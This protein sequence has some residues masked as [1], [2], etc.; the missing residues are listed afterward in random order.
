MRQRDPSVL[1]AG[2]LLIS[3][4][5]IA[6]EPSCEGAGAV[7]GE[8]KITEGQAGFGVFLDNLDQFGTS[9]AMLGDVD[10]D[11]V[12]DLAVGVI[13]DDDGGSGRGAVW[14]LFLNAD[15][16]VRAQQKISDAEGGLVG[17]LDD[18]DAFGRAVAAIGDLDGDG[19]P[20]LAVGA[21]SDDDGGSGRGAVWILLL[22]ANGAVKAE[23]KISSAAGGL[24]GPLANFIAFGCGV[25]SLGDLDGD[26]VADLAVGARN[27]ASGG[28]ARGAVWVLFLN[29]NGTVKAEQKIS[30]VDG[31]FG[32][33]LLDEDNFGR[34]VSGLGDLDGDG[35]PDLAVGAPLDNDGGLDSGAVWIVFLNA[36][37]T[38]KGE[39][40]IAQ[41]A[42]GFT[43]AL[44]A[45]DYF[46]ESIAAIGD[47]DGDG[48]TDLAAGAS[49]DDDGGSN[50]GAAWLLLLNADGTVKAER[51]ISSTSGGFT[52]PIA[53]G[54]NFG[55]TLAALGDLNGDGVP[56]L[57]VGDPL[58]DEGGANSG[59]V[60]MLFLTG[61]AASCPGDTNGDLV[62][63][64]A[65]LNTVLGDYNEVGA[66]LPGDVD[67]DGDV[68]FADLNI[69]LGA[70]NT[71]CGA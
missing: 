54:N 10:G 51:K 7:A 28:L 11:G 53:D 27:S 19:V 71:A 3:G 62:V 57:A 29:A 36:D 45:G 52:G 1:V 31:G 5:A 6:G 38:V 35:A 70:Y 46:G 2:L 41:S 68:D 12:G 20:D 58:D 39:Q 16:T 4:S 23:Q 60:W 25:S 8:V 69:V 64:F 15:G 34:S 56:D 30:D 37:G 32:G 47:L 43:G 13:G 9:A 40:K 24:A 33:T 42:G 66:G 44:G 49:D 65:D 63:D 67:G 48:V 18:G 22:N 59:A 61:C 14:I 17:A 26:G 55:A 50:R 21:D